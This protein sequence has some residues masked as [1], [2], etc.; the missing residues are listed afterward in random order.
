MKKFPRG[1]CGQAMTEYIMVIGLVSLVVIGGAKIYGK[2]IC[3]YYE[4]FVK[5]WSVPIP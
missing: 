5:V 3:N 1:K 4:N 2:V